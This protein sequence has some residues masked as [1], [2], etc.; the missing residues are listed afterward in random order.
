MGIEA[1]DAR[2][3]FLGDLVV[4]SFTVTGLFGETPRTG[5]ESKLW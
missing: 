5:A 1:G 2:I 3:I 4:V